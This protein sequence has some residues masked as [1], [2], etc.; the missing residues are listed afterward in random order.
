MDI[1]SYLLGKNSS[2]GGGGGSTVYYPYSLSFRNSP[3]QTIDLS[4]FDF[5][6]YGDSSAN[7][8]FYNCQ[9]VEEIKIPNS[10]PNN[11]SGFQYAF[12][13]C[14][15]LTTANFDAIKLNNIQYTSQLSNM[16]TGTGKLDDA[17]LDSLLVMLISSSISSGSLWSIGIRYYGAERIQALPHYQEF[18]NA[19]WTIE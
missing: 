10:F 2:G 11:L 13:N 12:N 1:V 14:K 19:G 4:N 3:A 16:F 6:N 5:S 17:S 18:V 7:Y 15:K 8:M 9:S